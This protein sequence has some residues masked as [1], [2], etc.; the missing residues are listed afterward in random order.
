[1]YPVG[2][3]FFVRICRATKVHSDHLLE[4]ATLVV[5]FCVSRIESTCEV[6]SMVPVFKKTNQIIY[7]SYFY[8]SFLNCI[9]WGVEKISV[10]CWLSLFTTVSTT[11]YHCQPLFTTADHC[12][13]LP[14]TLYHYLPLF[15][16]L[17]Q[18]LFTT[19]STTVYH[20]LP[21]STTA[22]HCLPL[23]TTVYHFLTK[24]I[25]VVVS[26]RTR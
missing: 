10:L 13:S 25:I 21:L 6:D 15:Q 23:S 19:V 14:T 11:L 1:M 2:N 20:L 9:S 3:S 16:P 5:V 26:G 12:R 7:W 24:F 22:N 17:F 8:E 18:P 4:L